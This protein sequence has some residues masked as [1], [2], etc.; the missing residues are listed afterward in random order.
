MPDRKML[1]PQRMRCGQHIKA[2]AARQH[3]TARL[4]AALRG[5]QTH[6]LLGWF[7]QEYR[8][9]R[10]AAVKESRSFM[11]YTVAHRKLR[12]AMAVIIAKG[13][14]RA[15]GDRRGVRALGSVENFTVG[16]V[17]GA[18]EGVNKVNVTF[19]GDHTNLHAV[20][21]SGLILHTDG[22]R[23]TTRHFSSK[24]SSLS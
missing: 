19:F 10:L 24:T 17:A 20:W 15:L 12:S 3:K 11:S 18:D 1:Q 4:E 6:G 23:K 2:L 5:A 16:Q 22:P 14:A 8:R 9:R 13:G 21:D 7:N